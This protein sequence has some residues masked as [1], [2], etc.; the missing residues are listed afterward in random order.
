[1]AIAEDYHYINFH[2]YGN[3]KEIIHKFA[4]I[5]RTVLFMELSK[6]VLEN[7]HYLPL[8]QLQSPFQFVVLD[9]IVN[10]HYTPKIITIQNS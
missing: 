7:L 1:M 8:L 2:E 10:C 5:F 6:V 3:R 4:S 9:G